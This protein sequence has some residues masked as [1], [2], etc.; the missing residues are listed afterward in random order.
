MPLSYILYNYDAKI[1]SIIPNQRESCI[2]FLKKGIFPSF[3]NVNLYFYL[4]NKL[5][6]KRVLIQQK[7]LNSTG[8]TIRVT[9]TLKV[10]R[11][12]LSAYT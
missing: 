9:A 7:I 3:V 2:R 10:C 11:L 8:K 5:K 6:T 4:K 12:R 1:I